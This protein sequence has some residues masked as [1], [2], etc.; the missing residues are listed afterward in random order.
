MSTSISGVHHIT[1]L[2][3][4]PQRNLV[5]YTRVLGLRL[6][7]KTVNFDAPEVYHLYYGDESGEPGTILTFFPFPLAAPGKRGAGE[8]SAVAFVVPGDSMEFWAEHLS[9]RGV[10]FRGPAIR[11]GTDTIEFL[12]PD[13]MSVELVFADVQSASGYWSGSSIPARHAIRKLFGATMTLRSPTETEELLV[14]TLGFR[15]AGKEGERIRY[16]I[17]EGPSEC[18]LDLISS[19][20]LADARQSAGSV[21]HIA[22]RTP[23]AREQEEWRERITNRG[24][25]VT[26]ILDRQ[27]FH[28]IYFREPGG[29]LFEIATDLP[30]FAI[31]E[32]AKALGSQLKLPPWLERERSRLENLLPPLS[33]V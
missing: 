17:G 18:W 13:G 5:F 30:G 21:H 10:N 7:K 15:R 26:P 6:V 19:S 4:D 1:A 22:W 14:D 23:G 3:S 27:Y 28:S 20:V 16:S 31:D 9:E 24:L 2:A 11:F 29:V 33:Y 8:I 32:A 25:H 12:D